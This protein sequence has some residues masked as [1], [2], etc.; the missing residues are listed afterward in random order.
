MAV[1]EAATARPRRLWLNLDVLAVYL[2]EAVEPDQRAFDR[3]EK[4]REIIELI[5]TGH[6]PH[7]EKSEMRYIADLDSDAFAAAEDII[8]GGGTD[9]AVRRMAES[10]SPKV[11]DQMLSAVGRLKPTPDDSM[12]GEFI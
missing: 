4:G 1:G 6:S 7:P 11:F 10:I 8:A 12:A 2:I 9:A 5:L 3:A